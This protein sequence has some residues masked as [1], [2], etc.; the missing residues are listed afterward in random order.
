MAFQSKRIKIIIFLGLF[1]IPLIISSPVFLTNAE[2]ISHKKDTNG[3]NDNLS[4]A[5]ENASIE[6]IL[7][8]NGYFHE[9][10]L[11]F[12]RGMD[13]NA[14]FYP[15]FIENNSLVIN[16][17][18][19]YSLTRVTDEEVLSGSINSSEQ[20]YIII[21]NDIIFN[22]GEYS[23][24]VSCFYYDVPLDSLELLEEVIDFTVVV[25][26]DPF[27]RLE[28][29]ITSI[30]T[31]PNQTHYV[32]IEVANFG[33]SVASNL[34]FNVN[35]NEPLGL[36]WIGN[37][38]TDPILELNDG[39]KILF[40]FTISPAS[41]GIGK[42]SFQIT[43]QDISSTTRFSNEEVLSVYI[44]PNLSV[45][46]QNQDEIYT[47]E[48]A[49]LNI[50]IY[51]PE[52]QSLLISTVL[53]SRELNILS[54]SGSVLF[55]LSNETSMSTYSIYPFQ[56]GIAKIS[57]TIWL[58]DG[59]DQVIILTHTIIE[60]VLELPGGDPTDII[61]TYQSTFFII[62]LFLFALFVVL[63][64]SLY[65]RHKKQEYEKI[66][67][68]SFTDGVLRFPSSKKAVIDGSNVAWEETSSSGRA[69]IKNIFAVIK[70]LNESN[71]EEI[72][73]LADAA[74]RYQVETQTT[75]DNAIKNGEIKLLPSGVE[76]DLFILRLARSI[77]AMVISNDAFRQYKDDNKWIASKR[78]PFTIMGEK[79]FLHPPR[80][81]EEEDEEN[82]EE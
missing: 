64:N 33:G 34:I 1:I 67:Q 65:F 45:S 21:S 68:V 55:I 52:P 46:F 16:T 23:L 32:Q 50:S 25:L 44:L 28:L 26:S 78:I 12:H 49:K 8:L 72:I 79:V 62:F 18:L 63:A 53:L 48:Q 14:T 81:S 9:N 17:V 10:N 3:I 35:I 80:M 19:N 22:A 39:E 31:R 57:I 27:V 59:A 20:S 74:L 2:Q 40:N 60:T 5:A 43:Y 4:I 56:K 11:T 82:K 7:S 47:N 71:F 29:N 54:D 77:G 13:V 66:S 61:D 58:V 15:Q 75:L 73:T 69:Q 30:N 76:G 37:W 42:V 70:K 41:F 24:A 38:T 6:I 36:T 51:N